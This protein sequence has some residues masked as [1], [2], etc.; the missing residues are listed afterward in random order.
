MA[1]FKVG[2]CSTSPSAMIRSRRCVL[3]L[4]L[5][6]RGQNAPA[7][8]WR[9]A[10]GFADAP[11]GA[12]PQ[13]LGVAPAAPAAPPILSKRLGL[14]Q[15]PPPGLLWVFRVV[16][17]VARRVV[18]LPIHQLDHEALPSG[19]V[20]PLAGVVGAGEAVVRR[21]LKRQESIEVADSG[22]V[23]LRGCA[24]LHE[25]VSLVRSVGVGVVG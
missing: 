10:S 25:E 23:P 21:S 2:W 9:V 24:V 19:I 3:P 18:D 13:A 4:G 12:W 14:L 20:I 7:R 1:L 8:A 15:A 6:Y 17:V 5:P 22:V 11:P 16:F